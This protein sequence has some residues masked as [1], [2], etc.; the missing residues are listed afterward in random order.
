MATGRCALPALLGIYGNDAEEAAYP[1]A[2]NDVN[3]VPLDGSQHNYTLTFPA[4]A[5]C[6]R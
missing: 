6:R 4:G 2:R 3:G 5:R 1:F